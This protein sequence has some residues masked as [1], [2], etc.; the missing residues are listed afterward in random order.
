[1]PRASE[2]KPENVDAPIPFRN[3]Q[4]GSW[5]VFGKLV[6]LNE[7]VASAIGSEHFY[8]KISMTFFPHILM[9]N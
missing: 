9:A 3:L 5:H 2:T 4:L 8:A 7:K 1:M 6:V